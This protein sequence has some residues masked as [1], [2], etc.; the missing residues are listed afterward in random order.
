MEELYLNYGK[1]DFEILA[2]NVDDNGREMMPA[3][4]EIT[5]HSFPILFDSEFQART[6]YGVAMFPE[7]F[8]VDKN[9]IISAKVVGERDWTSPEILSG[10]NTLLK[11]Q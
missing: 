6:L 10:L 5:P 11:G 3:F 4:L 2:I 1:E 9:G 7:T 8:I